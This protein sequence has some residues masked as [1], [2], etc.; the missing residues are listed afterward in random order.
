MIP[1]TTRATR[2]IRA[3][4]SQALPQVHIRT[5]TFSRL[6]DLSESVR[7]ASTARTLASLTFARLRASGLTRDSRLSLLR[8]VRWRVP[9]L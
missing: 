4:N 3:A 7:W 6:A 5:V 1:S 2:F 9:R 8:N